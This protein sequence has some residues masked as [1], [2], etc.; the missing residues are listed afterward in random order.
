MR[1]SILQKCSSYIDT[2]DAGAVIEVGTEEDGVN[3]DAVEDADAE[4][5]CDDETAIEEIAV[6]ETAIKELVTGVGHVFDAG[7]FE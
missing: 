3:A 5:V 2:V 7:C 4:E 6:R 1:R